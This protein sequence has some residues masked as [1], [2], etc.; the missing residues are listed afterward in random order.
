MPA[1]PQCALRTG[2]NAQPDGH[3][4]LLGKGEKE[5]AF[6]DGGKHANFQD[7]VLRQGESYTD[8]GAVTASVCFRYSG[9]T[10]VLAA[11]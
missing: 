7:F 8:K 6:N 3:A 9:N 4:A 2:S 11:T 1:G 10:Y 5:Q